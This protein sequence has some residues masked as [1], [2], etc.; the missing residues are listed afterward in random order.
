[1]V[2]MRLGVGGGKE[3]SKNMVGGVAGARVSERA[4]GVV[5]MDVVKSFRSTGHSFSGPRS[6]HMTA[7]GCRLSRFP[8]G[9]DPSKPTGNPKFH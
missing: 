2:G 6:N 1:M 3:V 8:V 9:V 5:Y 4:G 7:S